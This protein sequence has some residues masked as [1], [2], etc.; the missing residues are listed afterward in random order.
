MVKYNGHF[1]MVRCADKTTSD[2]VKS[3]E[4]ST[5]IFFDGDGREYLR[6][7]VA[8]P[9]S[10]EAAFKK[11]QEVYASKPI[12][13][14]TGDSASAAEAA[15][16]GEKK[17]L[18]ALAFVDDRKD[19]AAMLSAL[20]DRWLVKHQERLVFVK[21]AYDKASEECRKWAVTSAPTLIL[22]NPSEENPKKAVVDQLVA[23]K[24]LTT[25]HTF[26]VKA[27]DKIDKAAKN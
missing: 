17:K 22:V 16:G 21:I 2:K 3:S 8:T 4:I 20:E 6:Q 7:N 27:F 10:V 14:A 15:R 12:S 18:V 25:L 19:S 5:M 1:L 11:A 13:W 9:D 26:L 23:K 24:E